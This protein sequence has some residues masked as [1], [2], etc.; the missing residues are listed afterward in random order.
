[1]LLGRLLVDPKL[2]QLG[3]DKLSEWRN[4]F[5]SRLDDAIE[6]ADYQGVQIVESRLHKLHRL[7]TLGPFKVRDP[8]LPHSRLIPNI[9]CSQR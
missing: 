7:P 5:D 8:Y 9:C 1:M 4:W 3:E 6:A 2:K